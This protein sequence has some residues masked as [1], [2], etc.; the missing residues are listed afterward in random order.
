MTNSSRRQTALLR[1]GKYK[2][3]LPRAYKARR[4]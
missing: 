4:E 1:V 2:L 3:H